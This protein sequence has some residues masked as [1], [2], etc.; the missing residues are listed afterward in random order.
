M[1]INFDKLSESLNQKEVIEPQAIFY[2]LPNKSSK[3]QGYLRYVQ[4][5]VLDLWFKDRDKKDNIIKMNT[6]SGKTVVGLLILKS[7]MIENKGK[8]VYV[9]PDNYLVEQV[10]KEANDLGI[11]TVK[12]SKDYKFVSGNAI[13]VINIHKLINGKSIFGITDNIDIDN[14]LIDDVHSCLEIAEQQCMV[15]INKTELPDLYQYIFNLF[16]DALKNQNENNLLNM[17]TGDYSSIPMLVPFWEFNNKKTDV[18]KKI[19]ENL[20]K[21]ESLKFNFQFIADILEL[22]D[23]C[24][25]RDC[26]EISTRFLPIH[27]ISSFNKAKRRIFMSATLDDDSVLVRD[28]NVDLR[29]INII[30][31]EK[32]TDIGERMILMPEAINHDITIDSIKNELKKLS[33]D[34][35]IVV[36]VPS[37]KRAEYWSDVYDRVFDYTNINTINNYTK[38]LDILVNRYDGIDLKDDR[39]RILVID[40][41]PNASSN[42]DKIKE[43]MLSDSRE[44]MRE[45]VQK[46]EQ[47]MGRGIRSTEDY[48][49]I[50]ILGRELVKFL[51]DK[52]IRKYFSK[53][54]LKQIEMSELLYESLENKSLDEF[55]ELLKNVLSRDEGWIVYSKN[56]LDGE[57]YDK[58]LKVN[59]EEVLLR[60]AFNKGLAKNYADSVM[61]LEGLVNGTK[62][63][64]LKGYY[65]MLLAKY[66]NLFDTK[67]AQDILLS[68]KCNNLKTISPICGI[69]YSKLDTKNTQVENLKEYLKK[70]STSNDYII[71][72]DA[73][74]SNLNYETE[75]D[76]FEHNIELLGKALGFLSERPEKIYNNGGP[77]NL[78]GVGNGKY[79][80]IECKNESKSE[81]ICKADSGQLHNSK[82]WFSKMYFDKEVCVPIIIHPKN[83]FAVDASPEDDFRI[84][85]SICLEKLK[86]KVKEFTVALASDKSNFENDKEIFDKLRYYHLTNERF[87]FEYTI[88]I[89]N[90]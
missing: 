88:G 55:I 80:V 38:G 21:S 42:Y 62:N 31:P 77:D 1:K 46:I 22:C 20:S 85:D 84:M 47:G 25:S 56:A 57:I 24:I 72:V 52:R 60:T 40:G 14:I 16:Y 10:I 70:Y 36:I 87:I 76:K 61:I 32:V 83:L 50:L 54:T 81:T 71:E 39:C 51:F 48:C 68:A 89:K 18:L 75:A 82:S 23:C 59:E 8:A 73:I 58:E 63:N 17:K 53:A 28:F 79:Y 90:K 37:H 65:E 33:Q 12:D 3:Y 69:K 13:L 35:R 34:Y 30:C 11:E 9:V 67:R 43:V 27:K 41:I 74:L 49:G 64:I 6:G 7:S 29:N 26:I 15:T 4:G 2:R 44:L 45:K 19:I 5:E 78:W 66:C 86:N